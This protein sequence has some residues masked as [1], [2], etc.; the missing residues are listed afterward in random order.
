MEENVIN[1]IREFGVD[2]AIRL[3]AV[4][5]ALIGARGIYLVLKR[6]DKDAEIIRQSLIREQALVDAEREHADALEDDITGQLTER[7]ALLERL[8]K[9]EAERD[10]CHELLSRSGLGRLNASEESTLR[11]MITRLKEENRRLTKQLNNQTGDVTH[12]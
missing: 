4:G 2:N 1:F 6:S 3:V 7:Q 9:A 10:S 11:G 12:E 8:A 5:I